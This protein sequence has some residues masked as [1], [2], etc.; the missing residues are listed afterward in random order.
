MTKEQ[1]DNARC[2]SVNPH[3]CRVPDK[4]EGIDKYL[5]LEININRVFRNGAKS[6]CDYDR[7]NLVHVSFE[8]FHQLYFAVLERAVNHVVSGRSNNKNAKKG[9]ENREERK[10]DTTNENER[11]DDDNEDEEDEGDNTSDDH[12]GSPLDVQAKKPPNINDLWDKLAAME[13][14]E[15]EDEAPRKKRRLNEREETDDPPKNPLLFD[16]DVP[17]TFNEGAATDIYQGPPLEIFLENIL[18]D[19]SQYDSI[20]GCNTEICGFRF[21]VLAR[22]NI[23]F[24]IILSDIM[25]ENQ[26]IISTFDKTIPGCANPKKLGAGSF[27]PFEKF[28]VITYDLLPRLA[29]MYENT[30]RRSDSED[31][32]CTREG[33]L[34]TSTESI[35]GLFSAMMHTDIV[36]H[37]RQG[38]MGKAFLEYVTIEGDGKKTIHFP[39]PKH[40]IK[41]PLTQ[42]K[43]EI[44]SRRYFP[45]YQLE[46]GNPVKLAFPTILS[47]NE[48][49][50][51]I[52][53]DVNFWFM[54][55]RSVAAVN[56]S[57]DGEGS[58]ENIS[59]V[60][61]EMSEYFGVDMGD[62][63]SK[64]PFDGK[65]LSHCRHARASVAVAGQYNKTA[66]T[67]NAMRSIGDLSR[68]VLSQIEAARSDTVA[69][70]EEEHVLVL[71]KIF[72]ENGYIG[73]DIR[74][75]LSSGE[76][77]YYQEAVKRLLHTANEVLEFVHSD[78]TLPHEEEEAQELVDAIRASE[79][80]LKNRIRAAEV[81]A[82]VMYLMNSMYVA[83]IYE[84][85]FR[86]QDSDI[87]AAG[88]LIVKYIES[89]GLYKLHHKFFK[90]DRDKSTFLN[91]VAKMNLEAAH[92]WLLTGGRTGTMILSNLAAKDA[93][94]D[95]MGLHYNIMLYSAQGS[96]GKSKNME[97][98]EELHVPGT[99]FQLNNQTAK[100]VAC[101]GNYNDMI[102]QFPEAPASLFVEGAKSS[103]E[104]AEMNKA[105]L[106]RMQVLTRFF[107]IEATKATGKRQT[108]LASAE[109]IGM[110]MYSTNSVHEKMSEAM[111]SRMQKN[112]CES[113][114]GSRIIQDMLFYKE[115]NNNDNDFRVIK[116]NAT[117]E[118]RLISCIFYELEKLIQCGAMKP[119]TLD[120]CAIILLQLERG[121]ARRGFPPS[122]ARKFER[123]LIMC[124]I[125]SKYE[126]I[127]RHFFMPG[128]EFYQQDITVNSILSLEKKMVGFAHHAIFA[129]GLSMEGLMDPAESEIMVS[130]RELY[131]QTKGGY[132]MIEQQESQDKNSRHTTRQNTSSSPSSK[133]SSSIPANEYGSDAADA[134][135]L[136]NNGDSHF[137]GTL[138]PGLGNSYMQGNLD[139]FH[140]GKGS[141]FV[142]RLGGG[143]LNLGIRVVDYNYV[144]VLR[145][146]GS[147]SKSLRYPA[148]ILEDLS[149]RLAGNITNKSRGADAYSSM[150]KET[151][152]GF[153][154]KLREKTMEVHPMVLK[155][156]V[157][158][159][160]VSQSK[161]SF[162]IMICDSEG[163]A[164][165]NSW[166][167]QK[168]Y[169]S[170][171]LMKEVVAEVMNRH[172][173]PKR[174]VCLGI[175]DDACPS[176][177]HVMEVGCDDP[178]DPSLPDLSI[179]NPASMSEA[180]RTVLRT[181]AGLSTNTYSYS[182][183]PSAENIVIDSD[184]DLW[185]VRR[186]YTA[187]YCSEAVIKPEVINKT[188]AAGMQGKPLDVPE[189]ISL[190]SDLEEG[191]FFFCG[192]PMS[193]LEQSKSGWLRKRIDKDYT[194]HNTSR[195]T[196]KEY[197]RREA[198]LSN[199]KVFEYTE[200]DG[201]EKD[202]DI[203]VVSRFFVDSIMEENKQQT[204]VQNSN[205]DSFKPKAVNRLGAFINQ[206]MKLS[207]DTNK[208]LQ[209]SSSTNKRP[210]WELLDMMPGLYKMS[211]DTPVVYDHLESLQS[212]KGIRTF[213]YPNDLRQQMPDRRTIYSNADLVASTEEAR[214]NARKTG[215]GNF[216][217]PTQKDEQNAPL[218]G[219]YNAQHKA[220]LKLT[221]EL[222][223]KK[224][225]KVHANK[226][227]GK[228][229][230]IV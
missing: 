201:S 89:E 29:D 203:G 97:I 13:G 43:I 53:H 215:K 70:A 202:V 221:K 182:S 179:P 90:I 169:N 55:E 96:T 103:G 41:I 82:R 188:V 132:R 73:N 208:F 171:D 199:L 16:Q 177:Q 213:E 131:E 151:V 56:R 101:D 156:G 186:R 165:L 211:M 102:T 227:K 143:N 21:F 149:Q 141:S 207:V 167:F 6:F 34:P 146:Y 217:R 24:D 172:Y 123:D 163:I 80:I 66:P 28:R 155:E 27:G 10:G 133:A 85:E 45:T 25:L 84:R 108:S 190:S 209:E 91:I 200:Y 9:E 127:M 35:F 44:L 166:V 8:Y 130:I 181:H 137:V 116:K 94:R 58:Q 26:K 36:A 212:Y 30:N 183:T 126:A 193:R 228:H 72:R 83:R 38:V 2:W 98:V 60:F 12:S 157:V 68:A 114:G 174:H 99:C 62:L 142:G 4:V 117:T 63:Y 191:E 15:T 52:E 105:M 206:S 210:H 100:A 40:V 120:G 145:E 148:A 113:N 162:P 93:Y 218:R 32:R 3:T 129:A 154:K 187:L 189:E 175:T 134:F 42:C 65:I 226:E 11:D 178:E 140:D 76:G 37:P 57:T 5:V 106:T 59:K 39:F 222:Q 220:L 64:R 48:K 7:E 195:Y 192:L 107:D 19:P 18:V 159:E 128:G 122:H 23:P 20:T 54:S 115:Y 219:N 75:A 204:K 86:H 61:E 139:R 46:R 223:R 160:D 136:N 216:A 104:A 95:D 81:R 168:K 176:V 17:V 121:F 111:D 14:E 77:H 88:K 197:I 198:L 67:P 229:H 1:D 78:D 47:G 158:Q 185:S 119:P 230:K 74:R 214:T 152:L 49:T 71:E 194:I 164:F 224:V 135:D 33:M 205:N 69:Y 144:M 124:G 125:L 225:T 147:K 196:A 118:K 87:S 161:K 153:L 180:E 31:K 184:I 51:P 138:H 109:W 112:S 150:K 22:S 50:N 170:V 92:V 110:Q 173:Q 79:E